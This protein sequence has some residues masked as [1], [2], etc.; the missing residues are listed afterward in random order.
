MDLGE[1]IAQLCSPTPVKVFGCPERKAINMSGAVVSTKAF[2]VGQ[3]E[4]R[5]SLPAH[6]APS[7]SDPPE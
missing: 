1:L 3:G 6:L 7:A 5:C 2:F 4:G